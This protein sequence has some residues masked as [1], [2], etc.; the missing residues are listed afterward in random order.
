MIARRK[1]IIERMELVGLD[2]ANARATLSLL[3]QSLKIFEQYYAEAMGLSAFGGK[4]DGF[5]TFG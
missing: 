5:A 4:A 2:T 3:E 1:Q